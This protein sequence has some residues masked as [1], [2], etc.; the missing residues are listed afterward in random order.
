VELLLAD[1]R[2]VGE[3]AQAAVEVVVGEVSF[4]P[5]VRSNVPPTADLQ[6]PTTGSTGENLIF[7][8]S[9]TDADGTI[10]RYAFDLDGDGRFEYDNGK[11]PSVSKRYDTA[12]TYS[13]GLRVTDSRGGV[14]YDS[15]AVTIAGPAGAPTPGATKPTP[16]RLIASFK[17]GR[18]V[19]GGR[20]NRR[21][22]ARYRIRRDARV[23]LSLYRGSRRVKRIAGNRR[24][25]RSYRVLF[26]S[27]RRRRGNYTVRMTA[28][29]PSGE[30]QTARL[31]AK[32][33]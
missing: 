13:V 4:A 32:R 10:E 7:T 31:F 14:A 2:R 19:F 20:R 22:V 9:G 3:R 24:A 30:R 6:G 5:L 26:S 21:L 17:L 27:K 15:Q 25:N 16:A 18:P 12:G 23:T 11:N 8:G 29:T 33:L 1:L 28:V